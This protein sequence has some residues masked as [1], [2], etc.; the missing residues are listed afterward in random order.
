MRVSSWV[1]ASAGVVCVACTLTALDED[2]PPPPFT[3]GGDRSSPYTGELPKVPSLHSHPLPSIPYSV[4]FGV[5]YD[6]GSFLFPTGYTIL[7][8]PRVCGNAPRV[9]P[10]IERHFRLDELPPGFLKKSPDEVVSYDERDRVITFHIG[11]RS[12]SHRLP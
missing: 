6:T 9:Y 3:W 2:P 4:S 8:F 11:E 7:V 1:V 10:V 5:T 12:F